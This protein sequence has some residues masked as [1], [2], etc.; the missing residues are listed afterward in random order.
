MDRAEHGDRV[1]V[2]KRVYALRGMLIYAL[3]GML[4]YALQGIDAH[5]LYEEC[6][7]HQTFNASQYPLPGIF[8]T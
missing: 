2:V 7:S 5:L 3:Q 1:F 4:I 6:I 8:V